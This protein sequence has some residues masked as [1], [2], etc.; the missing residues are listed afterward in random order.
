M[1]QSEENK[2]ISKMEEIQARSQKFCENLIATAKANGNGNVNFAYQDAFA[3]W[4]Y[5]ELAALHIAIKEVGE[6]AKSQP[7]SYII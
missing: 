7:N 1:T 4:I 2:R 6:V 5:N 3:V